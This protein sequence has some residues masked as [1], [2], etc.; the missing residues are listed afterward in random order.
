M[1]TDSGAMVPAYAFAHNLPAGT[2][3]V[4]ARGVIDSSTGEIS[5]ADNYVLHVV[6]QAAP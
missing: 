5:T 6:P 4:C 2:Y 1:V 3:Y